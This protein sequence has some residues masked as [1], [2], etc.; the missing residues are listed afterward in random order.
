[1]AFLSAFMKHEREG[2]P[3]FLTFKAPPPAT[4]KVLVAYCLRPNG[5]IVCS[6]TVGNIP[7]KQG[8]F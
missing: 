6:K 4:G 3:T 1:M 7:C 8:D 2:V 5:E